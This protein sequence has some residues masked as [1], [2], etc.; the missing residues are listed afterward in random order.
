MH[1]A[2]E[3]LQEGFVNYLGHLTLTLFH[4]WPF[5]VLVSGDTLLSFMKFD[6]RSLTHNF[7]QTS[8][9]RKSTAHQQYNIIAP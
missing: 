9:L 1:G 3:L 6:N 7:C 2:G 4:G 5:S 8:M